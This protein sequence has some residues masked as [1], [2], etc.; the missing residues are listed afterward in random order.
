MFGPLSLPAAGA[1]FFS[2][3]LVMVFWGMLA[4]DL[5]IPKI[6]YPRA[7]LVTIALWLAV[8]PLVGV[9]GF[10]NR[11]RTHRPRFEEAS[12][13]APDR[14][15]IAV[16]FSGTS[17][18]VSS[19][20]LKG[21]KV[22]A[23]FGGVDLDLRDASV[24]ARPAVLEVSAVFGGV[25]VKVPTDWKVQI[26]ATAVFGGSADQRKQVQAGP[27]G[28]PHLNIAGTAVFGGISIQDQA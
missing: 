16:V 21:G 25:N 15:G 7:L 9:L 5:G 17:R 2:A 3:W 6:G 24:D 8:F 10:R 22:S 19:K 4:P 28:P 23:V 26:D 27:E 20:T 13:L 18:K 14:L 11:W 1:F 12:Q